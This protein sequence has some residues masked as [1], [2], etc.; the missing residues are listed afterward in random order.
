MRIGPHTLLLAFSFAPALLLHTASAQ[1]PALASIPA[2]ACTCPTPT[3]PPQHVQPFTMNQETTHIQ[4]L[5][6]GNV[7]K[8]VEVTYNTRDTEGRSR[9]E[10]IRTQNGE[11]DH[12]FQIYDYVT[13]TRYASTGRRQ[14]SPGR[15]CLPRSVKPT[16]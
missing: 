12:I 15:H 1:T 10:I 16:T 3:P 7:V 2:P 6:D 9:R 4:T 5:P 14:F 8:S 13:Q 11:V